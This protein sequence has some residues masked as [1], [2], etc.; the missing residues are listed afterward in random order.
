M[1]ADLEDMFSRDDAHIAMVRPSFT[2]S[3]FNISEARWLHLIIF[4]NIMKHHWG[5]GKATL[6][7]GATYFV[8]EVSWFRFCQ[9]RFVCID[10]VC[11][12]QCTMYRLYFAFVDCLQHLEILS[13]I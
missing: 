13:E 2:L 6:A 5:R 1:V 10:L 11:M 7:G 12:S 9:I 8:F 4:Y 3:N